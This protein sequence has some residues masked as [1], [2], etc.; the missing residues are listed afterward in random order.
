MNSKKSSKNIYALVTRLEVK[1]QT[2]IKDR[3][4]FE[5]ILF[6]I[7]FNH[8]HAVPIKVK[9]EKY[10]SFGPLSGDYTLLYVVS[11]LFSILWSE[12]AS[13]YLLGS[14]TDCM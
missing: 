2:R 8:L 13:M 5:G 1:V 10:P 14:K 6:W 3:W 12:T 7:D 9:N 4:G 11:F